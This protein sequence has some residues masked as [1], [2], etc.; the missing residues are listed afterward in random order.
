MAEA[1]A[2]GLAAIFNVPVE[3]V[4][5]GV[6]VAA[7]GVDSLVAVELCNWLASAGK[8]KLSIFDI[9][10]SLLLRK[11]AGLAMKRSALSN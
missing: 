5:L 11:F 6:A 4:D 7:Y 8:A 3:S 2:A 10:Q 1:L 9:L